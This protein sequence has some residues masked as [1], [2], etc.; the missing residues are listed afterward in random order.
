MDPLISLFS[1]QFNDRP[2]QECCPK[3][4]PE[5]LSIPVLKAILADR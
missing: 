4:N 1:F 5:D 3:W 2:I